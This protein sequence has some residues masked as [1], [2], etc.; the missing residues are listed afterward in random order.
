MYPIYHI[1]PASGYS[2]D[3]AVP[4]RELEPRNCVKA[5]RISLEVRAHPILGSVEAF[6]HSGA[7][8]EGRRAEVVG[9]WRQYEIKSNND[10]DDDN[11][12]SDS[13]KYYIHNICK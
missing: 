3:S 5:P 12:T 1:A 13:R 4:H 10:D 8:R 11:A 6:S 2:N 9:V 7:K